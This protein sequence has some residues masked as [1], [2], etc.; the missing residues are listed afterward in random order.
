MRFAITGAAGMLGQDLVAAAKA[1]GHEV[2]AFPRADLDITDSAAV[3]RALADARPDVVVNSAAWTNVDGAETDEAGA[4]AVNGTGAGNVARA[5][6]ACGAW[7]IH[8]S[9]D[10]V[11]DGR[12]GSPYGESDPVG[13]LSAYGRSKLAGERAVTEE[14]PDRHTT[15]RSS[16]L[17]GA[18]GPCFPATILRLARERDELKVVDDQIGCPTFTGHLADALVKLGESDERPIGI[19]HVAGGGSCSWFEFAREIVECAGVTCEV[20]PCSTEEFPRPATRPANS[21]LRSE[22]DGEAP[23]LPEWREGLARYMA[24]TAAAREVR[25]T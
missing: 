4:M 25:A 9:S 12:K 3:T 24:L 20:K 13:P 2:L 23:L 14:A 11:F 15:V 19:V 10:Y 6:A 5:A 7:T 17:F 22:R 1:A 18:A 16:W 8:V 21:V